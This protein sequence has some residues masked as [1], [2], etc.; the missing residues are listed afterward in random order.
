[1]PRAIARLLR[2][3]RPQGHVDVGR[4][5]EPERRRHHADDDDGTAVELERPAEH[6]RRA[7]EAALPQIVADDRDRGRAGLV[8]VGAERAA[9]RRR[10]AQRVEHV[11]AQHLGVEP[12]G[13]AA[14]RQNHRQ[15]PEGADA[16]HLR[17]LFAQVGIVQDRQRDGVGKIRRALAQDHDPAGIGERQRTQQHGVDDG[18]D[19]RRRADA[20]RQRHDGDGGE[21]GLATERPRGE[22][23]LSH[24]A[25]IMPPASGA[26][27]SACL[28]RAW[29]RPRPSC[30]RATRG[31][32]PSGRRLPP[33]S[34]RDPRRPASAPCPSPWR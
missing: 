29:R 20:E 10:H 27:P 13:L 5:K 31:D 2:E 8:I 21:A 17:R 33:V 28:S 23:Q 1:M 7:A 25:S 19:R 6:V 9:E 12:D 30:L 4:L 24:A 18:E 11:R 15:V 16:S 26:R 34:D 32:A 3:P 14:A 22:T